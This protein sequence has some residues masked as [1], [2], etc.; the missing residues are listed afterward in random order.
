MTANHV[1]LIRLIKRKYTS[2]GRIQRTDTTGCCNGAKIPRVTFL[3][4]E[5]KQERCKPFYEGVNGVN[6][7]ATKG[8]KNY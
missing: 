3:Y 5:D 2:N 7:L 4:S 1:P 6:R 8:V